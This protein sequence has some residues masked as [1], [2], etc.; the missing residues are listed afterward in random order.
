[1][2]LSAVIGILASW[3]SSINEYVLFLEIL[4][5]FL[6]SLKI[7]FYF[8]LFMRHTEKEAE[9]Q[10]EGEAGSQDPRIM[11]WA[12]VDAPLSHPGTLEAKLKLSCQMSFPL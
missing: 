4:A 3:N 9:T 6:F 11:T 5:A 2:V 8:Y 1:M 10:A 7:Y 12:K